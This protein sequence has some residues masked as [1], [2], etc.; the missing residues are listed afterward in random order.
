M[1]V[2]QR[3]DVIILLILARRTIEVQTE[4][5]AEMD[6]AIMAIYSRTNPFD[7]DLHFGYD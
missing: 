7:T 6:A 5:N 2:K 1:H 4:T 3:I